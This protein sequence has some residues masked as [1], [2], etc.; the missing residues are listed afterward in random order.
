MQ[1]NL[2]GNPK[3]ATSFLFRQRTSGTS[4][5]EKG[6]WQTYYTYSH[7]TGLGWRYISIKS[8]L[9]GD[10]SSVLPARSQL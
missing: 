8:H 9:R 5:A 4:L 10:R 2:I 3:R 7:R 1:Q 6:I